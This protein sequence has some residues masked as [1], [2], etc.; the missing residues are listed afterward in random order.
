MSN[1]E[2]ELYHYGVRGMKWGIRRYQNTDGTLTAAGKKRARQEYRED[3]R[4]AFE[5]GKNATISGRAAAQSMKRTARLEKKLDK[6]YEKDPNGIKRK[7]KSLS[8]Q[9]SASQR[10]TWELTE[11]Y[12]SNK[13]KAEEHCKSLIDKYGDEAVTSIK[14]KDIKISKGQNSPNSLTT[15]NE[16]TNNLS[17]YAK[18]GA[19][20]MA[21]VGITALLGSPVTMIFSPRTTGEKARDVEMAAYITNLKKNKQ[22][23]VNYKAPVNTSSDANTTVRTLKLETHKSGTVTNLDKA[24]TSRTPYYALSDKERSSIDRSYQD[25]RASLNKKRENATS[26]E[27][28]KRLLDEIDLLEFDYLS[29]VERDW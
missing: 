10:T 24:L 17:D 15:M 26:P 29:V 8:K 25:R 7:T 4:T 19:A 2:N 9:L 3:N 13:Q 27:E 23:D 21:S 11:Q 20:T 1:T 6:Q 22:A 28:R 18:A 12:K 16:R 5:L 14:Y